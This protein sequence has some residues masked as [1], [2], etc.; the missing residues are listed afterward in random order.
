ME[1]LAQ[2]LQSINAATSSPSSDTFSAVGMALVKARDQI[3][4][5]LQAM[6]AS[7]MKPIIKKLEKNQ[8]LSGEEKDL[9]RLWIVGDAAGF[10]KQET[11]FQQ[12]LEEFR[13]LADGLKAV[14]QM[15]TSFPEMLG[16][17]GNLEEAVRLAGDLQFFLEEKER[18]T[19]FDQAIQTL[20]ASEAEMLAG[21]LQE[22]LTSPEM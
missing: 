8:P 3:R 19:R 12:W 15:P 9:I 1:S 2:V 10:T 5:E 22:K 6:T 13:R 14:D 17:H 4:E 20:N 21:I 18:V 7:T 11:D 16:L